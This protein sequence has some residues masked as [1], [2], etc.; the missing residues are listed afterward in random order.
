MKEQKYLF[1]R[2]T[3]ALIHDYFIEILVFLIF[4]NSNWIVV[5]VY[6]KIARDIRHWHVVLGVQKEQIWQVWFYCKTN[7]NVNQTFTTRLWAFLSHP[8]FE[9]WIW[10][11]SC[12][13]TNQRIKQKW[14]S[15]SQ[16]WQLKLCT[17]C[18]QYS[19]NFFA[20]I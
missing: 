16:S 18:R 2:C 13:R 12:D 5:L 14:K 7:Q 19:L 3:C 20:C 6:S 17:N 11:T 1:N 8:I 15:K 10:C 9:F 4:C